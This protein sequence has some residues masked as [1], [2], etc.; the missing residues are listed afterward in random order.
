VKAVFLL[1]PTASGKT[2]VA[3]ELARR[4]PAEIVSVDSAQVY[5]GMDVGT[6]KPDRAE[7]ERVPHHLIDIVDPTEAYSAGRFRDDA[8][9]LV[10]EIHARGRTPILAGGTMLYFRALTRGLADL[11]PAQPAIRAEIESRAAI[12]GWP[13]LHRELASVDPASAE[14]IEPGDAQRIQRALE[15]HRHTGRALSSFHGAARDPLPFET[16]QVSL[17]PS[18]RSV[19]HER[20]A[21][22]FRAMLERGL[23]DEV[24]AL[25]ARYPLDAGM[26]SM[27]AVGY[28]QVWE[29]ITGEAPAATLEARGIA[30]TRQLAKRQLTWLRAMPDVERFDCLREDLSQAVGNR[31]ELF[32]TLPRG[33]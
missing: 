13:Q 11:P 31:A 25:R 5:R 18:E 15:V 24:K 16:L 17:E 3:L 10:N 26:P 32:L 23:A 20:I 27:R 7:R 19:L 12:S 30:A 9:R 22:R 4:F 28:R 29:T 14:R 8:L 1:G 33:P 21:R 6:A 2:A